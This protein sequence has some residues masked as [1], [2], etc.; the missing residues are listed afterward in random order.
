MKSLIPANYCFSSYTL[1]ALYPTRNKYKK[2][3]GNKKDD[4]LIL[5]TFISKREKSSF[6]EIK[7]SRKLLYGLTFIYQSDL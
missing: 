6:I 5:K 3:L 2:N 7:K 1:N 4:N